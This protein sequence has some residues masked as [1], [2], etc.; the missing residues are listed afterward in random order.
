[1]GGS[2]I[3]VQEETLQIHLVISAKY[4][5]QGDIRPVPMIANLLPRD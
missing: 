5:S 3:F 4:A 2:N 1:M